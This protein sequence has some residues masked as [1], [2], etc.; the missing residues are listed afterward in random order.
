LK[1]THFE[2]LKGLNFNMEE[3]IENMENADNTLHVYMKQIDRL[4]QLITD[5]INVQN[6][7]ISVL[8]RLSNRVDNLEERLT[9]L[10][11]GV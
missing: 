7:L 4:T 3:Y 5:S 10:E 9:E 6:G 2:G 8:Q 1:K 11:E